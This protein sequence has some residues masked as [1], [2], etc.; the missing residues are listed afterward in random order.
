[1]KP[2]PGARNRRRRLPD[3]TNAPASF[4]RGLSHDLAHLFVRITM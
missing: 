3:E 2:F 4:N 1:M